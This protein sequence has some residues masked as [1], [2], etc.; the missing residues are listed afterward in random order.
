MLMLG[1]SYIT[2]GLRS[3]F[4]VL[5]RAA[6]TRVFSRTRC[7]TVLEFNGTKTEDPR[8]ISLPVSA[9]AALDAHRKVQDEFRPQF[10]PE[11]PSDLDLIFANPKGFSLKADPN[12]AA[13]SLLLRRLKLPKGASLLSL[14]HTHTS[15]LLASGV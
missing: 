6:L 4:F 7:V 9:I 11:Y 10:G 13:V 12:S 5:G 14:R 1:G 3:L 8:P 15:H 2:G